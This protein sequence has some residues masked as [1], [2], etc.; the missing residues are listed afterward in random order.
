MT[1]STFENSGGLKLTLWGQ[2]AALFVRVDQ[3]TGR[4][5]PQ[6]RQFKHWLVVERLRKNETADTVAF[7]NMVWKHFL[8]AC[9]YQTARIHRRNIN[10]QH[11]NMVI[12]S[13]LARYPYTWQPCDLWSYLRSTKHMFSV[14][15]IDAAESYIIAIRIGYIQPF[16]LSRIQ[17][18]KTLWHNC[19]PFKSRH[20]YQLCEQFFVGL[21]MNHT[22]GRSAIIGCDVKFRT[23]FYDLI[24]SQ[25]NVIRC[26][27]TVI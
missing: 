26:N 19:E 18:T 1:H 23:V 21:T 12:R 7:L 20:L 25:S 3:R 4:L 10:V 24:S 2:K 14:Y 11:S 6:L 8:F 16:V 15:F 5:N 13:P 17:K 22:N 9:R 27:M